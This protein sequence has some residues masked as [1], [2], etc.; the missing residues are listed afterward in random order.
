[1]RERSI[2]F[3]EIALIAGTRGL[4]GMG[5]GLLVAGHLSDRQRK[6]L[7]LPLIAAGALSTIP[8]AI[9]LLR[10]PVLTAPDERHMPESALA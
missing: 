3:P 8:L 5:I 6:A 1:M 2:T 9:H 4:L 10:K 7:A